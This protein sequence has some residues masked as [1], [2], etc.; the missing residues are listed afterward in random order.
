MKDTPSPSA[1]RPKP[2][3]APDQNR[4]K[5]LNFVSIAHIGKFIH[6]KRD[7]YSAMAF[8]GQLFLPPYD[9]CTMNFMG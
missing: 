4:G 8:K 3:A 7:L 1:Q 9:L 6:D 5:Q 2:Q